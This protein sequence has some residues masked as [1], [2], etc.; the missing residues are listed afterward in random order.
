MSLDMR[1]TV[2]GCFESVTATRTVKPAG[3][4]A[5]GIWT[6][7]EPIKTTH[8]VNLQPLSEK[9]F[10]TLDFGAKRISDVRKI[11]INDGGDYGTEP[12]EVWEFDGVDGKFQSVSKDNRMWRNY[13]KMIVSRIDDA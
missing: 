4:D 8:R 7:S 6:E 2:S 10:K 5:D 9:E 13:C 12:N 1:G 11:Y 3:Y